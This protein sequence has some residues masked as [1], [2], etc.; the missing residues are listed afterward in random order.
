MPARAEQHVDVPGM[1]QIEHAVREDEP[2]AHR[3][4][5]RQRALPVHDFVERVQRLCQSGPTARGR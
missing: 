1:Q 5:P 4:A 2:P 3:R